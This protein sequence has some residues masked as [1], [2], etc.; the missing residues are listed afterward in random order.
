MIAGADV[1]LD[2]NILLH[3]A[4]GQA[5][6]REKWQ[7]AHGLLTTQFGTS[8]QVLAEFY[9][10]AISKGCRPLSPDEAR[11]WVSLLARKPFVAADEQ[12][13]LAGIAVSQRFEISYWDGAVIAAAERLGAATLYTEGLSHGQAYGPVTVVNPFL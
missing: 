12:L 5:A 6:D 8:A 1:F 3:A 2:T 10:N 11:R 13:V 4:N 9:A 7:V